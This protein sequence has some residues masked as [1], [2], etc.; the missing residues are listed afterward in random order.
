MH[1]CVCLCVCLCSLAGLA[2]LI[3]MARPQAFNNT[4]AAA[5]SALGK[6]I[7]ASKA[8]PDKVYGCYA[9]DLADALGA[10]AGRRLTADDVIDAAAASSVLLVERDRRHRYLVY[11]KFGSQQDVARY[12]DYCFG[13]A[14]ASRT[15]QFAS[16]AS[17]YWIALAD[18][19]T[20]KM[21]RDFSCCCCCCCC[22]C[23]W[24]WWWWSR[25]GCCGLQPSSPCG[26]GARLCRLPST[27]CD[28]AISF[29][30]QAWR[31]IGNSTPPRTRRAC[32]RG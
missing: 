28:R 19:A 22:C 10:V 20:W 23:C 21:V 7:D 3:G 18:I 1:G 29:V 5:T 31:A 11:Q 16:L 17:G 13:D 6:V 8:P 30:P 2:R 25:C 12:L 9:A 26:H 32:C 27:A 4:A 14:Y 15:S 24:W